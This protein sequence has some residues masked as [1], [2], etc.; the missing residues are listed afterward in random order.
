[1]GANEIA[2]EFRRDSHRVTLDNPALFKLFNAALDSRSGHPETPC[3]VGGRGAGIFAKE[4]DE[5]E[6]GFCRHNAY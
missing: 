3:K 1:M 2:L 6:I 5:C 4:G